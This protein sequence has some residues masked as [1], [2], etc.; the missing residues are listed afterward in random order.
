M[1]INY[2]KNNTSLEVN[3][4]ELGNKTQEIFDI[5][6]KEFYLYKSGTLYN[7]LRFKL[8]TVHT[9]YVYMGANSNIVIYMTT[10]PEYIDDLV[11]R[12]NSLV[13]KYKY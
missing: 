12:I 3:I 8:G 9:A 10:G 1:K 11:L 6:K 4:T 7:I 2:I 5:L 13:S